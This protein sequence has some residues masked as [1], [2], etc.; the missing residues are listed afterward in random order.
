MFVLAFLNHPVILTKRQ[1]TKKR[2]S[3]QGDTVMFYTAINA[4][5][6]YEE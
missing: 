3:G 6:E 2:F 5:L 4:V 1:D